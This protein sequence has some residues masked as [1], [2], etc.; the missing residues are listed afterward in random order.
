[1]GFSY[2]PAVDTVVDLMQSNFYPQVGSVHPTYTQWTLD[3]VSAVDVVKGPDGRDEMWITAKYSRGGRTGGG[4][5]NKKDVPPWE[6]GP[7]NFQSTTEQQQTK[8]VLKLYDPKKGWI[9][10]VNTAGC[11][12]IRMRNETIRIISFDVNYEYKGKL[13]LKNS[14]ERLNSDNETVCSVSI[15]AY[16][17]KLMPM[18]ST[19]HTVYEND[20][21]TVKWKYETV[22]VT[23]RI[24][25][26]TWIIEDL[27]VGRLAKF[28]N[29]AEEGNSQ[30]I[31][32]P[33]FQYTPW[34]S[35]DPA[36]NAK[37]RPKFG[38]IDDVVIAQQAYE[39]AT[40][41]KKTKI[42]FSQC[43]EDLPLNEHGGIYEE[44]IKD[45]VNN[46][47]LTIKGYETE[48]VS[49]KQYDLPKEY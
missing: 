42:P 31:L 3:S 12:L 10:Y 4:F 33:I 48:G 30:F 1:M 32:G 27:N 15:P 29:T 24:N 16:C 23:I 38:S 28:A 6:L 17:G 34:T 5:A 46:P 13:H 44:A 21:E 40:G 20:G 35:T 18:S 19:L 25:Q 14:A 47:Y 22:H 49:W 45:P 41:D 7:Q 43:D 39:R 2:D 11:R 37:V 8:Q 26:D 36:V 9:P